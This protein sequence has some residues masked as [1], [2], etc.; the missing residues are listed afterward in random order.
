[1]K[2]RN[3]RILLTVAFLLLAAG[4]SY[5]LV[6]YSSDSAGRQS[7]VSSTLD[8]ASRSSPID[9]ASDSP[10]RT[11]WQVPLEELNEQLQGKVVD[12]DH[13]SCLT[14]GRWLTYTNTAYGLEISF[15]YDFWAPSEYISPS[16][17]FYFSLGA[18]KE[19]P[20]FGRKL[21]VFTPR[22]PNA[23]FRGILTRE[24][25]TRETSL[26]LPTEVLERLPASADIEPRRSPLNGSDTLYLPRV[27]LY[28]DGV[29][30][31]QAL[32]SPSTNLVAWTQETSLYSAES[33]SPS[34]RQ[35]MT[36]ILRTLK[37]LTPAQKT[38]EK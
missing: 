9:E 38:K 22:E 17:R 28:G 31:G 1:M 18:P 27:L 3:V 4:S 10:Q 13:A 24:W 8:N 19:S 21:E 14:G 36:A 11:P 20:F 33:N 35:H 23:P 7:Q 15:P 30:A 6:R 37:F 25:A 5:G 29:Y 32:Y 2:R 12:C 26:N 34:A 16:G